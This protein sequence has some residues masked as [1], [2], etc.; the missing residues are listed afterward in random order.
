[1][2]SVGVPDP[3]PSSRV[4]LSETS[5]APCETSYLKESDNLSTILLT[6][7]KSPGG[8]YVEP[9]GMFKPIFGGRYLSYFGDDQLGTTSVFLMIATAITYFVFVAPQLW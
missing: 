8:R 4:R 7:S 6:K 9:I 3:T 1:M 5:L 2:N